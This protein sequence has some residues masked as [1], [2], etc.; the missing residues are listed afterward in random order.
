MPQREASLAGKGVPSSP[1]AR[2]RTRTVTGEAGTPWADARTRV[3]T[4]LSESCFP[5]VITIPP[6]A[7]VLQ[8]LQSHPTLCNPMDCSPPGSSVHGI[9]QARTLEWV[10]LPSSTG[11][12]QPRDWTCLSYISCTGMPVLYQNFCQRVITFRIFRPKGPNAWS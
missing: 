8:S 10:A 11:S 5:G 4:R 7:Y 6:C 1:A 9:S 3:K 2:G 12:S